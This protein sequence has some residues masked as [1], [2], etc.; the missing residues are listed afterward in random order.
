MKID[1]QTGL[2]LFFV[3]M[4]SSLAAYRANEFLI[5]MKANRAEK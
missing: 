2:I 1:A 4:L 3:F 5:E